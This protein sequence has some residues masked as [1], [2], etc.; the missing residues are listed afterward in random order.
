[1]TTE[2]PVNHVALVD[3]LP[4]GFEAQN[5]KLK[6]TVAE[7]DDKKYTVSTPSQTWFN[8]Q[9]IRDERVEVFATKVAVGVFKF[10]YVARA[11][12]V[13]H[14]TAPPTRAEEMYTP[15]IFGHG[16]TDAIVIE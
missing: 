15:D 8:H 9:N 13:G 5:T 12:T 14:F 11:T 1:M 3:Y 6:G 16:S 2:F 4:A 7:D 10:D